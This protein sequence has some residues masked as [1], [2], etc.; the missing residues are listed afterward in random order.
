MTTDALHEARELW[1]RFAPMFEAEMERS[2]LLLARTLLGHL[3]LEEA[4]A[5]LEVGAGAGGA[6]LASRESLPASARHVVTDLA[7]AMVRRARERLPSSVAVLE[8]DACAL[9]FGAGEFDRLLAN[10]NLML[11]PDADAALREAARVLR[12]GARAAWS[13]W[14]RPEHSAM[15]S[16]P[17]QAAREVGLELPEPPRSNFHLNDREALLARVRAA[18]FARPI[19]WH[20]LVGRDVRDGEAYAAVTLATPRWVGLLEGVAPEL[21]AA[22]RARLVA[23]ADEHLARGLPI[24]LDALIVVA[25]RGG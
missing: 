19:A 10:L 13:V 14:G 12:P 25:E 24:G 4:T 22:F 18:G 11:V 5:L 17:P 21:V 23:L 6:A 16:L 3:R 7:P 8:A 15:F 20:Q 9:P 1:D 2:T